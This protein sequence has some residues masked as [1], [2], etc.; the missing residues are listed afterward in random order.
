MGH[1]KEGQKVILVV[2]PAS[3][4]LTLCK[5]ALGNLTGFGGSMGRERD[6]DRGVAIV[7]NDRKRL[8]LAV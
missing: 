8:L 5:V 7:W 6:R 4:L 2:G 1:G 3:Q